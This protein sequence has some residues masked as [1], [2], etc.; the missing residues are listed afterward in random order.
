MATDLGGFE[1]LGGQLINKIA[2]GTVAVVLILLLG[3]FIVGLM[4]YIRYL[5]QFNIGVEIWSSRSSGEKG[6]Q[7]YKILRDKGGV[8]YDRY[9]KSW[10][11]RL[12]KHKVDLPVP[13]Y[14]A[15]LIDEKGA[16]IVK[17][18]QKSHEEF[19]YLLPSSIDPTVVVR[20]G[21][22][23]KLGQIK[24]KVVDGDVSYWN[25]LRKRTNKKLFDTENTIMKLLPYIVPVLMFML[26]IFMTYLITEKWGTFAAAAQ[27]LKDAA[28]S[29][30]LAST[31]QVTT[32]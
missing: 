24:L 9:D 26:V 27:A 28:E 7:N 17:I 2:T 25:M 4:L 16:N 30:R 5:R 20:N 32:G 19:F 31:A 13:P 18:W 15:F 6:G 8:I 3:G 22:E 29:L 21:I 1:E 11:F 10:R 23:Y 12:R 14:E